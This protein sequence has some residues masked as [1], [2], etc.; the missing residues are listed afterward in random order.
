MKSYK[1]KSFIFFLLFATAALFYN[2]IEQE[3]KF[4]EKV[5][6]SEVVDMKIQDHPKDVNSKDLNTPLQ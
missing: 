4:K 6:S 2:K 3:D 1:I 5:A